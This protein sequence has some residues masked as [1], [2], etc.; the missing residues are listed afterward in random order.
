MGRPTPAQY[1]HRVEA[2]EVTRAYPMAGG[3]VKRD[4]VEP[5]TVMS[6]RGS[7]IR[8]AL[9]TAGTVIEYIP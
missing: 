6:W 3:D 4:N 2:A 7:V 9:Q 8:N 5:S 1:L